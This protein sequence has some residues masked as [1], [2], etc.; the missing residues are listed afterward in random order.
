M[1]QL[2]VVKDEVTLD[3]SS[4]TA[5]LQIVHQFYGTFTAPLTSGQA[6][7][8]GQQLIDHADELDALDETVDLTPPLVEA[9]EP[10]TVRLA[11]GNQ[12]VDL[13]IR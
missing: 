6:R 9:D 2:A 3:R 13:A 8:I 5:E 4:R 7:S 10:I 12:A 11:D 1:E